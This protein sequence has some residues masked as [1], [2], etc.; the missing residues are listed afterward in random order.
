MGVI[1][2]IIFVATLL[3]ILTRPRGIAEGAAAA[4]GAVLMVV[5]GVVSLSGAVRVLAANWDV[6][7]FFLGMLTVTALAEQAGLFSWLATQAARL[8]G[9]SERRLLLNVFV[10]GVL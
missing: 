10:L 9:G 6:F 1:A 5:A 8:A 4:A 2:L 7:L 3:A